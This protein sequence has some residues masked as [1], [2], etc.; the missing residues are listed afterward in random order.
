MSADEAQFDNILLAVAEK[1][2]GGVPEVSL[3]SAHN[4]K[5]HAPAALFSLL[6]KYMLYKDIEQVLQPPF[7]KLYNKSTA[8]PIIL[9]QQQIKS[10]PRCL[11]VSFSFC[12][13]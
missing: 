7:I 6:I 13:H 8:Y 12:T 4:T 3:F 1:H 5:K 11:H 10:N 9:Q 2:R